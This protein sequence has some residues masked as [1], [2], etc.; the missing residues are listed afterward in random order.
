[1]SSCGVARVFFPESDGDFY[2]RGLLR[3]RRLGT[4]AEEGKDAAAHEV[5]GGRGDGTKGLEGEET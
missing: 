4:F 5:D 1:M 3:C 2:G